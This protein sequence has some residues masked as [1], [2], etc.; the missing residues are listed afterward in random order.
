[1]IKSL[2]DLPPVVYFT[3]LQPDLSDDGQKSSSQIKGTCSK[4]LFKKQDQKDSLSFW[5][6]ER[7]AEKLQ[8]H[9]QPFAAKLHL[10]SSSRSVNSD[11]GEYLASISSPKHKPSASTSS[12]IFPR[13]SVSGIIE[14]DVVSEGQSSCEII[15][16]DD[17]E[18]AVDKGRTNTRMKPKQD[19]TFELSTF[20]E[21]V[22]NTS[23]RLPSLQDHTIDISDSWTTEPL[24]KS[25]ASMSNLKPSFKFNAQVEMKSWDS[26]SDESLPDLV[27]PEPS[28]LALGK[29]RVE[30]VNS[31]SVTTPSDFI[32]RLKAVE[33][34]GSSD[35]VTEDKINTIKAIL[36][37]TLTSLI[38]NTLIQCRGD[39]QACVSTL[40]DS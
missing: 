3:G 10:S 8:N 18:T 14:E 6:G 27:A 13:K 23:I 11:N 21:R 32:V 37:N 30:S 39:M 40:L 17:F 38:K 16:V 5:S 20:G 19:N 24:P 34:S 2:Y 4:Q 31:A 33:K 22:R 29:A 28:K 35:N 12:S 7:Q 36:P 25:F 9:W 1:M 15:D 26:D